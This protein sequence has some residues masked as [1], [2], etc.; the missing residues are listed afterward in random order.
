VRRLRFLVSRRWAFFLVAVVLLTWLAVWLGQWQFSRLEDRKQHNATVLRNERMDP[1]PV[2]EVLDTDGAVPDDLE[3]RH[4]TVSGR[5]LPEETVYV[6]YRTHDK[7]SGVQVVV[8]VDLGDGTVVLVDRGWW[9]TA[10]RGAV[11]DDT[12][13]PP[14]GDVTVEGWVR[15]D[16]TGDSTK[17]TDMST[18]AVN[19]AAIGKAIDR[20]V[21]RGFVQV[22]EETPAPEQPLTLP[23]L[24]E[25]NDGPHFFY[26]LQWWFFGAM[27]V[28]GFFYLLYDE[29]RDARRKDE[30]PDGERANGPGAGGPGDG[31]GVDGSVT[32]A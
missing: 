31:S 27:A 17:V 16:A 19:S 13:A 23:E 8:P 2:Q 26:G 14:A 6:R 1:V 18:R 15:A 28:F 10:N 30:Q 29:W 25:L 9:P 5:Y 7:Q 3:W 24:P 4:V 32:R 21:R 22:A 12:P 20:E 11:P